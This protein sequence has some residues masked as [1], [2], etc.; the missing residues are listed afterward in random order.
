MKNEYASTTIA[1]PQNTTINTTLN[2][3]T[4]NTAALADKLTVFRLKAA[5]LAEADM[6]RAK[7][8][9]SHVMAFRDEV[10][11]RTAV[12]IELGHIQKQEGVVTKKVCAW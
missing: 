4:N 7:L 10:R 1:T 9:E 11:R 2:T 5:L 6:L 3:N 8:S 12:L